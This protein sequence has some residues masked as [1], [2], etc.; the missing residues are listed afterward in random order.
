MPLSK[1][2]KNLNPNQG[3]RS[4]CKECN[5]LDPKHHRQ[6]VYDDTPQIRKRGVTP[7]NDIHL[8][9]SIDT[10][11]LSRLDSKKGCRYCKLI[12]NALDAFVPQWTKV[13]PPVTIDLAW[14]KPIRLNVAIAPKP[15]SIELYGKS[16]KLPWP[17]LGT[18]LQI[19]ESSES[20]ETYDFAMRCIEECTHNPNHNLCSSKSRKYLPTRLL[21]TSEPGKPVKLQQRSLL[22]SLFSPARY[23][24]LSH[25]WGKDL[26]IT[27]TKTTLKER[28]KG[29]P[30]DD[31]PPL[32]QDC[33]KIAHRLGV[34]YVWIDALCI[35]QDD[36]QDW[37]HESSKMATIY[38]DALVTVA[39]VQPL[40]SSERCLGLR[41]QPVKLSYKNTKGE[42]FF[43]R[44]R[45]IFEHHPNFSAKKPA[46][47]DGPLV[48]RAWALQEHVLCS[49][50]LHYTKTEVI[51]ECRN[52]YA[53]ECSPR[54]RQT[55]VTTPALLSA[56]PAVE[57]GDKQYAT[58]HHLAAAFSLRKLT[59]ASDKLPAISGM[60]LKMQE[61]VGSDYLAG[62]WENNLVEEILWSSAPYLQN[63][64]L[65]DRLDNYRAPSWSWASVDTQIRYETN[66]HTDLAYVRTLA[67]VLDSQIQLHNQDYPLGEVTSGFLILQGP[68]MHGTLFGPAEKP[69]FFYKLKIPGSPAIDVYPDS[70]LV[71]DE[72]LSHKQL[73][74]EVVRRAKPRE[75][76]HSFKSRV[77]CIGVKDD[78][79]DGIVTGLV[80]SAVDYPRYQRVGLFSCGR[81]IFRDAQKQDITII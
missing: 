48:S 62:V 25:C 2:K 77:V 13:R 75:A 39:A 38:A 45:E 19:P 30:W 58:W 33:M 22:S 53:C 66:H 16:S 73:A 63:P 1:P 61:I 34:N 50:V 36:R 6:S 43:I 51:F 8:S 68:V 26:P 79:R 57:D 3:F 10:L 69:E 24:A 14:G 54:F 21:K 17:S 32:F 71:P 11:K 37:E 65:A 52:M 72:T 35:L 23:I 29:I 40:D 18:A 78:A 42:E 7:K 81:D 44:A 56:N 28:C 74:E 12:S 46:E 59:R 60:A 27:T 4:K 55:C 67:Q 64:M 9:L 80:L 41:P 5:N 76:Y 49:R 47:I 70:L 15:K 20:D 31:L